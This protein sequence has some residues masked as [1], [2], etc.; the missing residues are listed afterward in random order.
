[1]ILRLLNWQGI[2]GIAASVALAILL[3]VQ[4]AETRHWRKQS[5]SFDQLYRQEQSA[6]AT[7]VAN[8]RAAADQ[9]RAADQANNRRVAADQ[10]TINERTENDL[11]A[12]LAAVRTRAE[13]LRVQPEAATNPRNGR[14]ASMPA[15]SAAAG[16]AAEAAD[17]GRLSAG[18]ALT[19]TEQAIQLD[20]LIKWVQAQAAVD[21][22]PAAVASPTRD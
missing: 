21:N 4:K 20:E 8:A 19:A 6:F 11:E 10:R 7:T 22:N 9:A 14:N 15:L 2:A 16:G 3:L 12:R 13:R 5:A 18:D 1:M 17:Q